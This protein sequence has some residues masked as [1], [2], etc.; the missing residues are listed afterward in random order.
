MDG[1]RWRSLG[2]EGAA[3]G[4]LGEDGGGAERLDSGAL[5]AFGGFRFDLR[6]QGGGEL[7]PLLRR[8]VLPAGEGRELEGFAGCILVGA[9]GLAAT[10]GEVLLGAVEPPALERLARGQRFDAVDS[11]PFLKAFDQ[12]LLAAVTENVPEACDLR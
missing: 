11:R 6:D 1:R 4:A 10:A 2:L 9:E 3:F 7:L 5:P 12:I 8:E